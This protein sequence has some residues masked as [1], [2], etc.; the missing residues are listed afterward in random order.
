[1]TTSYEH[2]GRGKW[3]RYFYDPSI[4]MWTVY[5]V[6]APNDEASQIGDADYCSKP[7]LKA[8]ISNV[9]NTGE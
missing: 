6:T 7:N 4:R 1:M 2:N 5:Q 8:T 3:A 9:L